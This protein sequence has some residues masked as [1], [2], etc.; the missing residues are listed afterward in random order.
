MSAERSLRV[1]AVVGYDLAEEGGVKRNA[2][3]VAAALQRLGD[4]VTVIGPMNRRAR[5]AAR[6]AAPAA[7]LA[8]PDV[9]GFGGVVNIRGNGSD[10]RLALFTSPLALRRFFRDRDFDVVHVHEP[11]LPAL[12]YWAL[13]ASRG[14]AH[15]CTFH[16]YS[17]SEGRLSRLVRRAAGAL[18]YR[19][20]DRGIAVSEPAAEFARVSWRRPLALIPNGV[21]TAIYQGDGEGAGNARAPGEPV[22]VLFVGHFRDK[23]KGLEVL[24]E[25]CRRL[26]ARGEAV[27]LDVVGSGGPGG[28][29]DAPPGVTFH[30]PISAESALAERYRACDI[31]A[32]TA[33]GQESFGIVLLEAMAAGKPIAC[34][35]IAGYRQVV[36]AD[37][38]RFVPPGDPARLADG[39][40]ALAA[41]AALRARMGD[42]NRR[43]AQEFDW[44]RLA[45]RVREQYLLAIAD[46]RARR[47]PALEQGRA[48]ESSPTASLQE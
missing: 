21:P 20:F 25:A 41:D 45:G 8:R 2:M 17:E 23:R 10:N 7:A 26:H 38:A 9:V 34:S 3:H 40:A 48:G 32:A 15:V 42:A 29:P 13:L 24:L 37:G 43:R 11:L 19:A 18:I 47:R 27:G 12:G 36:G 28:L 5:A 6:T 16:G 30:G 39:I 14:A 4:E 31:F 22:R 33:T 44:E 1:C 35:D 46:R